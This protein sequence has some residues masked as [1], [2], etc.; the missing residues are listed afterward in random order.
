[1]YLMGE[2]LVLRDA[3]QHCGCLRAARRGRDKGRGLL[4]PADCD[5]VGGGHYMASLDD[6][7][8][9]V[10]ARTGCRTRRGTPAGVQPSGR[11]RRGRG[12]CD[13]LAVAAVHRCL[14]ALWATHSGPRRYFDREWLRYSEEQLLLNNTRR[15]WTRYVEKVRT[16]GGPLAGP[17]AMGCWTWSGTEV[18]GCLP[19]GAPRRRMRPLCN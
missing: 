7:V 11:P 15:L 8:V 1:M 5:G 19:S 4:C 6:G 9:H 16:P 13:R 2:G 12:G 10:V 14:V 3:C 18:P 17:G